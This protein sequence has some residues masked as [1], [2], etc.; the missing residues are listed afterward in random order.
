MRT[1]GTNLSKDAVS[2][3]RNYIQKLAVNICQKIF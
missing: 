2:T 1:D 3:F